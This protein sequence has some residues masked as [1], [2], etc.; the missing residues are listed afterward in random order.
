MQKR[1]FAVV[2]TVFAALWAACSSST[3]PSAGP[4]GNWHVT[5]SNIVAGGGGDTFQIRPSPFTLTISD[6][7]TSAAA[8]YPVIF[9]LATNG[10]TIYR[11]SSADAGAFFAFFGDSIKLAVDNGSA[12][13]LGLIGTIHGTAGSGV[14]GVTGTCGPT[15]AG[16]WTATK[17]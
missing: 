8:T 5:I 13:G 16:S 9:G 15:T 4:I 7:G 1:T 14:A 10:D 6:T 2:S 3:G 12:C 17:Y 11:W